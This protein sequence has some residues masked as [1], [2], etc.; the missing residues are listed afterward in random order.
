MQIISQQPKY[1]I[2]WYAK[3]FQISGEINY[4]KDLEMEYLTIQTNKNG[5]YL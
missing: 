2:G 4:E 1:K 5:I 3:I